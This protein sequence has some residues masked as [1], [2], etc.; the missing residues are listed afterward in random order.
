M[1][2]C[3]ALSFYFV[4]LIISSVSGLRRFRC[5]IWCRSFWGFIRCRSFWGFIR[6]RSG[7]GSSIFGRVRLYFVRGCFWFLVSCGRIGW[8]VGFGSCCIGWLVIRCCW[9]I[10]G[11]CWSL[12]MGS[13]ISWAM[14]FVSWRFILMFV[15]RRFVFGCF[16]LWR[17]VFLR[18]RCMVDTFWFVCSMGQIVKFN[19]QQQYI[20]TC[21]IS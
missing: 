18:L 16:V 20:K 3:T 5:F 8:F 11:G 14:S 21:F 1:L 6:C 10:L 4:I 17:F 12:I 15:L 13:L 9:G 19:L 2:F 7:I